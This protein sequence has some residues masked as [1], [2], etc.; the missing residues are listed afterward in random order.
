MKLKEEKQSPAKRR[1]V[2][3]KEVNYPGSF[4]KTWNGLGSVNICYLAAFNEKVNLNSGKR[5]GTGNGKDI[6]P[7]FY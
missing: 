6:C 5:G 1:K 3:Q 7:D 2:K 4:D